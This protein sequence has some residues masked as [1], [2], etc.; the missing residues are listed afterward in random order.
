M[1]IMV[2][3]N[4]V[5]KDK[6][7]DIIAIRGQEMIEGKN[8]KERT[9]TADFICNRKEPNADFIYSTHAFWVKDPDNENKESVIHCKEKN[10]KL[11]LVALSDDGDLLKKFPVSLV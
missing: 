10:G 6:E 8:T 7:G 1:G 5:I 4:S 11:C 3:V 9:W 2:R